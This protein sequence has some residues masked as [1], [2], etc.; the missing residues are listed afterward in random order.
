MKQIISRQRNIKGSKYYL[1]INCYLEI[2]D[3][4][5]INN[6]PGIKKNI[7]EH[8][9]YLEITKI[10]QDKIFFHFR[11]NKLCCDKNCKKQEKKK[12]KSGDGT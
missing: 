7:L 9:Y 2:M 10:S 12:K 5:G 8:Q 1:R 11:I 4:L 6:Y 3:Y